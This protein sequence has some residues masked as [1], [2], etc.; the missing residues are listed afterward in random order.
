MV[1]ITSY[2]PAWLNEPAPGH[3]LFAP[4]ELDPKRSSYASTSSKGGKPKPGPRRTIARRGTEVFVANGRELR[5]GDLV[6]LKEL[7]ASK[8]AGGATDR[9][10]RARVK[11]E[12]SDPNSFTIHEDDDADAM[13]AAAGHAQGMRIIKT[14]V[15]DDIKQLVMSPQANYLAVLTT[16]T[17][18]ICM[19]PDP[20]HLTAQDAGPLK[21]KFW[22]LGPTTHVTSKSPI[23]S[24]VFHPLGVNGSALVTVTEEAVVRVWELSPA[25]RW[26]F[27]TPTLAVDLRKLADGTS[28]DQDFSASTSA[29]NKGFSPDSFDMEV[30][31]ACFGGGR[32]SGSWS[33][34]TLWVAMRGGDLYALCPLLPQRWAPPPTLIPSLS[35]SIVAKLAAIED[36]PAVPAQEKL[37]AQQQLEW[38]SDLDNQEPRIVEGSITD[39]TTEIFTRPS[40]P[41]AVPKLQG[42]FD[43]E[44]EALDDN[45]L[46]V[47]LT[48]IYVI[49][50][51]IDTEDLMMGEDDEE[52]QMD[53][54]DS[55]GL[56]LSIICLVSTSG[57]LR[58]CL[59]LEGVQARWLPSA[60]KSRFA[61][62]VPVGNAPLPSLLTFQTLDVMRPMEVT[63][64]AWPMISPDVT[65]RYSFFITHP[66][67]IALV[68]LAPWVFRLESELQGDSAAGSEFRLDLLVKG[69]TS[70]R[71]RVFT[72]KGAPLAA[73]VAIRDPD[74]GYFLL[75]STPQA[76]VALSFEAPEDEFRPAISGAISPSLQA[77]G[78]GGVRSDDDEAKPLVICE[79]R[80]A[81]QPSMEVFDEQNE[82]S[83]FL[84]I[85]R[86]SRYQA[87]LTH[88]IRLSAASLT[89]LTNA[90]QRIDAQTERVN[91][92]VGELFRRLQQLPA[93]LHEQV[94][95]MNML[96]EKIDKI[97]GE[98]G[99]QQD[100]EEDESGLPDHVRLERR[101]ERAQTRQR[102]LA[103]RMDKIKRS[104]GRA[105]SRELSDKER[106]WMDEV[107]SLEASVLGSNEDGGSAANAGGASSKVRQYSKRFDEVTA[108]KTEL[109]RQA[110]GLQ[111]Q[112]QQLLQDRDK[113][114]GSSGS[115]I[116]DDKKAGEAV[117]HPS[118]PN[119]KIPAD[120]RKAKVAQVMQLLERETTLVEAVKNR[121]EKLTMA[122]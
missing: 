87:V 51:K 39:P 70:T 100:G 121:L 25:D 89:V 11:R 95:K 98:E 34:M 122:G 28:L 60:S 119:M 82:I 118:T 86:T 92:A 55:E 23:M 99:A 79:P 110:E 114:A 36:D 52:L 18:H 72:H 71:D 24:A 105:N 63:A 108:L 19:L 56:S 57:Q 75:S 97:A 68:S 103:E 88:E 101:L 85:A 59:D 41:G 31:A 4:P 9:S 29:M 120:V 69:Q 32:G 15:A 61:R 58:V 13:F 84:K 22:T 6:Y 33:S 1:K 10:G 37:L 7:W 67:G 94:M 90:H 5:W 2:T 116:G 14:P 20:S 66:A 111:Q 83:E 48:D 91:K 96:K 104:V 102:E 38:M 74:L 44:L 8:Q 64:D 109:V 12:D 93:E 78:D 46:D 65:S 112:R 26:S 107:R 80:P 17:V 43:L 113:A 35:V 53:D 3:G 117:Q 30:A 16:H 49:G 40:R 42:P 54:A 62:Q 47:E 50:E 81:F 76:A 106:A 45:D 21:A 77:S 27:D 73:A 115:S